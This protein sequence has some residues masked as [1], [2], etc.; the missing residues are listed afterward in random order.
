MKLVSYNQGLIEKSNKTR[1]AAKNT[2]LN[3]KYNHY[4]FFSNILEISSDYK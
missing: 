1:I 2:S 3:S 4:N